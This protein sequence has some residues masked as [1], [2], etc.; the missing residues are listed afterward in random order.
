VEQTVQKYK[1]C[2]NLCCEWWAS[3]WCLSVTVLYYFN[4]YEDTVVCSDEMLV[5]YWMPRREDSHTLQSLVFRI[6]AGII[7]IT[8]TTTTMAI[9]AH[10]SPGGWTNRP[11]G[12]R[13]SETSGPIDVIYRSFSQSIK[14]GL[15]WTSGDRSWSH[16]T[17]SAD[18]PLTILWY[19]LNGFVD[20]TCDRTVTLCAHFIH[21]V[22]KHMNEA[23]GTSV[24]SIQ[25][26]KE[27]DSVLYLMFT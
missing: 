22:Q 20:E 24:I 27:C 8:T 12:G 10:I 16:W 19:L 17:P 7:I 14:V 18:L 1:L 11:V 13:G 25:R 3:H 2:K 9:H 6:S 26:V 21:F 23:T 4:L 15:S 5:S